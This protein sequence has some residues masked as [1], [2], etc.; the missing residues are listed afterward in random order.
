M[1]QGI[2]NKLNKILTFQSS[3]MNKKLNQTKIL[4]FRDKHNELKLN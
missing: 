2:K 3:S 1:T 4:I